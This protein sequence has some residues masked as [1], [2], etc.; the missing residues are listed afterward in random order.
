MTGTWREKNHSLRNLM[1]ATLIA[2]LAVCIIYFHI[3]AANQ[4]ITDDTVDSVF[5]AVTEDPND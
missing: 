5:T 2:I 3:E 1:I 4:K